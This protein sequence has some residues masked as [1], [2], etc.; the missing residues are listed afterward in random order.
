MNADLLEQFKAAAAAASYHHADDS[1]REWGKA[2]A[3]EDRCKEIWNDADDEL[4]AEIRQAVKVGSY[5]ISFYRW[6]K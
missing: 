4:K 5:L 3:Y 2:R 6:G 1:G